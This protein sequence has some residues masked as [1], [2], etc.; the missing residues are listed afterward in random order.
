M[1]KTVYQ[2]LVE[3][4]GDQK[5]K[6]GLQQIGTAAGVTGAAMLGVSAKVAQLAKDY[7]FALQ[8]I[9]TVG[10][11]TTGSVQELDQAFNNLSQEMDGA[12]NVNQ[13][14][15]ASYD[16]ASAGYKDQA[17][18]LGI[19][20]TSQKAAIGGYSDL[21]TVS[22]ATTTIMNSFGDTLGANLTTTER[23]QKVTDLLIQTQN[24]GKTTVDQLAQSYGNIA[25]TA[26]TAGVSFEVVNAILAN[27][28]AQGLSTSSSVA[29]LKQVIAGIQKPTAEA[30]EEAKRLGISFDAAT[31][32]TKGLDGVLLEIANSTNLADDSI[33][34]L[35][36]STEAQTVVNQA[37]VNSGQ[38]IIDNLANQNAAIGTTNDA[39][40]T[41]SDT[42]AV[43]ADKAF[44][45]LQNTLIK[46]GQGVL[47]AVEPAIDAIS[48]LVDAFSKLPEPVQKAIGLATVLG[49]V[50]LTLG[51]GILILATNFVV[52]TA[53][54]SAAL[55]VFTAL[56][57]KLTAIQGLNLAGM[58]AGMKS[59]GVA[60]AAAGPL[61]IAAAG[62]VASLTLAFKQ[63]QNIESQLANDNAVGVRQSVEPLVDS[64][65]KMRMEMEKTGKAIP[66][67]EFNRLITILEEANTEHADLDGVI[68][69]LQNSQ[70]KYKN[71]TNEST[72]ATKGG[73]QASQEN[74]EAKEGETDAT[75]EGTTA[76]EKAAEAKLKEAE[77]EQ[78]LAEAER[79]RAQKFANYVQERQSSI[80]SLNQQRQQELE[81]IDLNK[82]SETQAI[83][84][85]LEAN[86]RYY[87]LVIQEQKELLSQSQLSAQQRRQVENDLQASLTAIVRAESE[88][89]KA[90]VE[91]EIN[92]IQANIEA[93]VSE[94]DAMVSLSQVAA[95]SNQATQG[96]VSN[97]AG[98]Y[99]EITSL[100]EDENSSLQ[101][102][103]ELQAI[104]Q[105]ITNELIANGVQ[106]ENSA[107]NL[108]GWKHAANQLDILE[109]ELKKEQ[110]RI[111]REII[112][113][114]AEARQA[115]IN[116]AIEIANIQ[117]ANAQTDEELAKANAVLAVEQKK[118][119]V[120]EKQTNAKLRANQLDQTVANFEGQVANAKANEAAR[121]FRSPSGEAGQPE[122]E[123]ESDKET[124]KATKE[125]A[126][127]TKE[128]TDATKAVG[129]SVEKQTTFTEKQAEAIMSSAESL[130]TIGGH[131]K[132]IVDNTSSMV[133]QLDFI[134]K[135]LKAIPGQIASKIPRPRP[136]KSRD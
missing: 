47:V 35:F 37:L 81:L 116:G 71:K 65:L 49:G 133:R 80:S 126:Q 105:N 129:D 78:R 86:R 118:L 134:Q 64:A 21:A 31:L 6:A 87:G 17:D 115:E 46:L 84:D 125:T 127:K 14:A 38:N 25:A 42:V 28:T 24:D 99:R 109:I 2:I 136:Q 91:Q 5:A 56:I 120:L 57:G 18:I 75:E 101:F 32:K 34:R 12:I 67:E 114:E 27:S 104:G 72:D 13:A 113:L 98:L 131:T 50:G 85:K 103:N 16:V 76:S 135:Q 124:A 90:L 48:F 45:K 51:G 7:D 102:K 8:K 55:P 106:L 97:I 108:V 30:A 20:E 23:A 9:T 40:E 95:D 88:A 53:N 111:Q 43:K 15:V 52:L 58:A 68:Q 19:L 110:L 128:N 62:A 119:E 92:A 77:E 122:K 121:D 39:Y 10:N 3:L 79:E 4:E 61:L 130:R 73:A 63:Y 59:F 1:A 22:D 83:N 82:T 70:E 33:A 132:A 117:K 36:G 94:L 93:A 26:A 66:D 54:M 96:Y 11:E 107:D 112:Q 60:A 74:K 41:M 29:G 69:S 44:N 100:H 123:T 89:R